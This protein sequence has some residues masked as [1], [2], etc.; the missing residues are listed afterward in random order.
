MGLSGFIFFGMWLAGPGSLFPFLGS[1]NFQTLFFQIGIFSLAL[2]WD[3][4]N[5]NITLLD[6]VFKSL[7]FIFSLFAALCG[8]VSLFCLLVCWSTLFLHHSLLLNPSSVFP[9]SVTGFF[10]LVTS[11]WFFLIV[12]ISLLKFSLCSPILPLSL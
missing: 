12:S 2:L 8:R 5:V 3:S 7:I 6:V 9:S 10:S 4:H 11:V 1:G